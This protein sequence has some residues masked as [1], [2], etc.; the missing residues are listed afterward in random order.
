MSITDSVRADVQRLWAT[1][2]STAKIGAELGITKGSVIGIAHRLGL[3][4]RPSPI[5]PRARPVPIKI[6]PTLVDLVGGDA[7]PKPRKP[8]VVPT[9]AAA[10]RCQW[11][12]WRDE[13]RRPPRPP[14]FCEAQT[15]W[16][17]SYC[18]AHARVAFMKLPHREGRDGWV[19][20]GPFAHR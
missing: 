7:V 9:V 4:G 12:M 16:G 15:V 2:L 3:P 18:P 10:H 20:L 19:R 17:C 13:V 14:V 1:G 11:P 8:P 6:V 5:R